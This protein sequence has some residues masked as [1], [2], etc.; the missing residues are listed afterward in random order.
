MS[1]GHGPGQNANS[2]TV[3]KVAG[4][5]SL[6]GVAALV[7]LK[8]SGVRRSWEGLPGS[9]CDVEG[10]DEVALRGRKVVV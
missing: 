8:C 1:R 6:A 3:S 9:G 10:V 4:D 5:Q 2:L 7:R